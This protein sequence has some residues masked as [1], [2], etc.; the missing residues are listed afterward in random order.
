MSEQLN[1]WQSHAEAGQ[2]MMIV[3]QDNLKRLHPELFR[4]VVFLE[5]YRDDGDDAA[6][7]P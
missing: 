6:N 4:E 3:A 2:R 1:Y 7:D 5:E